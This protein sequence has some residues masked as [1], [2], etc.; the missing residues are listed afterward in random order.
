MIA[1]GNLAGQILNQAIVRYGRG[2]GF[3]RRRT[4]ALATRRPKLR[5][6]M[7]FPPLERKFL[8]AERT[9]ETMSTTWTSH[10]PATIECLNAMALAAGDSSRVGRVVYMHSLHIKGAITAD[11]L[12]AETAPRSDSVVRIIVYIDM[13]INNVATDVTDVIDTGQSD[14]VNAFRNLF[15]TKRIVVLMDKMIHVR[16][17]GQTVTSANAFNSAEKRIQWKY[18]KVW[19]KPIRVTFSLSTGV[20]AAITDAA[21]QVMGIS[22]KAN[23]LITYQSRL[24]FTDA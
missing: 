10:D 14:D 8:D 18:N 1:A 19:K 5:Y 15:H 20:V 7:R 6:M 22:S 13:H 9:N 12:E 24:R 4:T 3:K 2:S 17:P 21:I 16:F 23:N 11:V